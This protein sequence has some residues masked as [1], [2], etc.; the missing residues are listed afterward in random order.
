MLRIFICLSFNYKNKQIYICLFLSSL[1]TQATIFFMFDTFRSSSKLINTFTG[2]TN[3]VN[4]IDHS[5]FDNCQFICS[6]SSDNTVR[7]WD[8]D[9]NEQL[10]SFNGH[11][12]FVRCVKFSS[13]YYHNH[14]LNVICS[15]SNDKTIHFWDFKNNEQ[16]QTFNGHT[17]CVGCIE[18]SPFNGGR[19][20]CSGSLDKTIRLW[21]VETS[22]SLH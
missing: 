6:G 11:S 20:L 19:Y 3:F 14:R 15:S 1:L 8:V 17:H 4:S 5:T 7:V 21:D 18:F 10:Q 16:L 9:S 2:H 12:D 13:Y 22:K